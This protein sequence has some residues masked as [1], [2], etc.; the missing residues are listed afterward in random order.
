MDPEYYM[1][2]QLTDKSDVY[3]FGVVLLELITS[4]IPIERG[5]HIVKL[6]QES[7][8]SSKDATTTSFSQLVDP[9][10]STGSEKLVS[11]MDKFLDLAMRCVRESGADRP[12]MGEVVRE[13]EN[14]MQLASSVK[15]NVETDQFISYTPEGY[16]TDASQQQSFGSQAFEYSGG[17]LPFDLEHHK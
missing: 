3:S 10:I 14:I 8:Q 15:K 6:V 16:V 2:Q 17:M 5:K 1:T 7:T 13:I 12:T 4:R 11:G 9:K